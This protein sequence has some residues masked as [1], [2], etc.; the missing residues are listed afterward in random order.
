MTSDQPVVELDG[1]FGEGGGQILRSAL[2]LSILSRRGI[3]IYN[4]RARRSRPGLRPQHLKAVDAA[5]SISKAQVEGA[6][7]DSQ[8]IIFIPSTIRT[9][10]YKFEIG[11]AGSTSLV[12]QTIFLPLSRANSASS[13]IIQGGTHVPW[14]PCIH[15]LQ[16]VW[17]P[18]LRRIGYDAKLSLDLAGFY[19][20]GGGRIS[21][22]IR[23]AKSL[24][25][26][27]LTKRGELLRVSGVSGISNLK[28]SIAERQK[29]QA[30]KRLQGL[31]W[32]NER[33]EIKIQTQSMPSNFKG[34]VLLLIGE[35]ETGLCS[36][37]GLGEPGKPAER[38]AD[39]A[40]D[41]FFRFMETDGAID[42]YLADQLL[43]PACLAE[44]VSEYSTSKI[45]EHLMTNAAIVAKFLPV[46][47]DI[48][49]DLQ[50]PGRIRISPQ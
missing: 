44:G 7:L 37:F 14:S 24:I 27:D 40:V 41:A 17:L 18:V 2:T 35:F 43:L 26:V 29:R 38:V 36:Y 19:P 13:V 3:R 22:T 21:A 5:A 20:A 46:Q 1:S 48:L 31:R 45:T 39:E 12:L 30:V 10:R 49:G 8:E 47:I 50:Q 32:K 11:T 34:T 28:V 23:P 9:G 25:P 16:L 15:Y 42:E 6:A 4:I 33:P